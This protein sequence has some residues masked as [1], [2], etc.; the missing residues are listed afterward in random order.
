[1]SLN[2]STALV[3]G[4]SRGIGAAIARRLAEAGAWV[5]LHANRTARAAEE[6]AREIERNGGKAAAVQGDLSSAAGARDVVRA[7]FSE[8]GAL[9]ILV[10]N[11]AAGDGGAIEDLEEQSVLRLLSLNIGSVLFATKEFVLLSR[12]RRGRIVNL[13]SIAGRLPS[14]GGSVYAA[15]KAAV[16]S[17][18]RSHAIELGP[19]GITVNAVAPGTTQTAMAVETFPPDLLRRCAAVTPLGG[20]GQPEKIVEVVAFLCSDG[21]SWITG[22]VIG[23]DGGQPTST[24]VLQYIGERLGSQ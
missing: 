17:L 4:S 11:A 6:I 7:A 23:V 21:A 15:T 8:F 18:T 9:D 12:S 19:R 14:P 20:L 22:Q 13:S 16:E 3:T 24:A 2:G 10:N 1:M 5:V